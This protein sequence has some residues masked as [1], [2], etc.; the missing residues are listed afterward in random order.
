[1]GCKK[2]VIFTVN[3]LKFQTL[4]HTSFAYILLFILLFLKICSGMVNSVDP[5]Q[6]A[7]EGAV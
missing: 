5:D 4:F 6:I 1:M 7:P 3:V 2:I